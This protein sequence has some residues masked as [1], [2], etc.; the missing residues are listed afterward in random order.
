ML[1]PD[2]GVDKKGKCPK[3]EHV[4]VIPSTTTGRPAISSDKEPMPDRPKQPYVPMWDKNPGFLYNDPRSHIVE[5]QEVLIDLYK[6]SFGFLIPTYD[7]LSLLLMVVTLMLLFVMNVEMRN[8]IQ[9]FIHNFRAEQYKYHLPLIFCLTFISLFLY[10]SHMAASRIVKLDDGGDFKKKIMLF[11]AVVINASSGIIAG[12]YVLKNGNV[13]GWLLVFPIW[14]IINGLL[15]ILMLRFGI[16]DE[17]CISDRKTTS[18]QII[19]G[20]ASVAVIFMVCN[21]IFDLYWAVTFSICVVY[22]TS[23]DRALQNVLP[24]LAHREDEQA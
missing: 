15:L 12:R 10:I 20:L 7:K 11:F 18:V 13:Q 2:D 21:Y 8:S 23:F 3:C 9:G 22:T 19:L 6:E 1:A 24:G 14:N 5:S 17:E 16:I 4:L